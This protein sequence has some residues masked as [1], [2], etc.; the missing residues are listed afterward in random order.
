MH[1]CP[2]CARTR[3]LLAQRSWIPEELA[4][5]KSQ[6]PN[7]FAHGQE[8]MRAYP[9]NPNCPHDVEGKTCLCMSQGAQYVQ[10]KISQL[11]PAEAA[12]T[13]I[14]CQTADFHKHANKLCN[15]HSYSIVDQP[16]MPDIPLARRVPGPWHCTHNVRVTM[17]IVLKD[18]ACQCGV[19]LTLQAAMASIGLG[20]IAV[21]ADKKPRKAANIEHMV[22]TENEAAAAE[23]GKQEADSR[24]TKASMTGVEVQ[25][26][27]KNFAKIFEA[28]LAAA[29]DE[30]EELKLKR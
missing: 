22:N 6:Q 25:K 15:Q 26:V 28:M 5:I 17:W 3:A 18:T 30:A 16:L 9:D 13:P 12:V 11:Y 2:C 21:T 8:Q 10:D 20:N 27:F 7:T 14:T 23:V 1:P 4:Y 24:T 29:D 19:L